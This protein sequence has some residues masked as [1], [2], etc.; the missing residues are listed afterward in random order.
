MI[1][2]NIPFV[3]KGN[4]K[5]FFRPKFIYEFNII[6]GRFTDDFFL[7]VELNVI[8]VLFDEFAVKIEKQD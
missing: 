6:P 3:K 5:R 2:S 1:R 7:F 8:K 4:V